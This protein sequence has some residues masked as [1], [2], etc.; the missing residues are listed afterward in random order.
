MFSNLILNIG[1][2]F[3]PKTKFHKLKAWLMNFCGHSVSY[4][5]KINGDIKVYGKGRIIIGDNTWVG[6]GCI[7]YTHPNAP[8]TIKENCDIGPGVNFVTGSHELGGIDRRA[9]AGFVKAISVGSGTWIGANSCLLAGAELGEST[10][11]GS[12]SVIREGLYPS[13]ILLAGI[14]AQVKKKYEE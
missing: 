5:S 11:V 2:S 1:L 4:S 14:P 9:G 3:Y 10:V 6:I 13:S 12:G 8:I 7:F